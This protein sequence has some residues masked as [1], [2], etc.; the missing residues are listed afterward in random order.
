MRALRGVLILVLALALPAPVLAADYEAGKEAYDRSDYATALEELRPLAEQGDARA[1]RLLGYM[2][3][4]GEGIPQDYAEAAKWHRKAAEQGDAVAQNNLGLMYHYGK[5]V[6][7]DH[8]EAVKWY[9][10]AANQDLSV[11]QRKLGGMYYNSEG[12]TQDYLL[13]HMW[14][15]LA[16]A[17]SSP[18]EV[19]DWAVQD[20]DEVEKRMSPAQVA[21]AQRLAREWK[22]K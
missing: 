22:P 9:Q 21:E 6:T 16:A 12:V 18:G 11:A 2:Y 19:H 15:N 20:R 14:F 3:D 1:Q 10:L 4:S 8:A 7:Q 5:G 13:A 17:G